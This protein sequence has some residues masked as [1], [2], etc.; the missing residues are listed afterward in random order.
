MAL[1]S[2][3]FEVVILWPF[4]MIVQQVVP[5]NWGFGTFVE[6]ASWTALKDS[7]SDLSRVFLL[8]SLP[9]LYSRSIWSPNFTKVDASLPCSPW[10]SQTPKRCSAGWSCRFGASMKLSWFTLSGLFGANP[11]RVAN[12]NFFTTF[13][14]LICSF[15]TYLSLTIVF[16]WS[17]S[18]CLPL[19]FTLEWTWVSGSRSRLRCCS[20]ESS[21]LGEFCTVF[22]VVLLFNCFASLPALIALLTAWRAAFCALL[23]LT[24]TIW[25]ECTIFL[26]MPRGFCS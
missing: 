13:F 25:F 12:A 14:G 16:G 11:I 6:K 2:P 15:S 23:V 26:P 1:E 20:T 4:M 17:E 9:S 8:R 5:L 3:T 21:C 18:P 7:L 19:E 22:A 10:P 24:F